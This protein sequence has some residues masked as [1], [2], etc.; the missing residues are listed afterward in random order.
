MG[1]LRRRRQKPG[2]LRQA[3]SADVRYLQDWIASRTGIEGFIEPRT[4]VTDVTMLLVAVT[5]EWTRRRVPSA[6]WAH[7]FCNRNEIPSYDA[8]VVGVPDRMREWNRT[9]KRS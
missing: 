9:H 7:D 1:F 4:A 5:G 3:E 6:E 2:T 8:A